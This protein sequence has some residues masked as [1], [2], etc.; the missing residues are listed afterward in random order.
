[1]VEHYRN[2][3]TAFDEK[4]LVRIGEAMPSIFR[5]EIEPLAL[6]THENLLEDYYTTA[7]GMP[8]TYAQI[9]RYVTM[10]SHKHPN[11]D[12][13][14]IGAGTGGTTVPVLR[15]LKECEDRHAYSYPRLKAYTYTDISSYFF[16]RTAEKFEDFAPF[17]KFKKLDIDEDPETQDFKPTSYDVIVAANVLHAT[18]D[19]HRTMTHVRKLLRPGAKLILLE[20]TNRLLAASVIFG[21]LPG[22]WNASEPWRTDGP[23]LTETQWENVLLCNGFSGLQASSPDVLGPL[24]EGTMLMIATAVETKLNLC[25][26]LNTPPENPHIVILH[27]DS[28]IK[29]N[30]LNIPLAVKSTIE[31]SGLQVQLLCLSRLTKQ[32][33]TDAVCISFV[34][35][36]E[37]ILAGPSPTDLSTLQSIADASAGLIW[38]TLGVSSSN[39]ES[40]ELAVF[41]GL[42]RTLRAEHEGLPCISVDLDAEKHLPAD[43]VARLLFR[44]VEKH[45]RP[46]SNPKGNDSEFVE[47]AGVLQ[48]KR[49]IEDDKSNKFL[50][51]RTDLTS[52]PPLLGELELKKR[53]LKLKLIKSSLSNSFVFEDDPINLQPLQSHEVEIQVR[54]T[55]IS[56][57]DVRILKDEIK[58]ALLGQECSGIITNTGDAVSDLA[59]GDHVVAWCSNNFDTHVHTPASFVYKMLDAVSFELAA[60]VPI[61]HVTAYYSLIHVVRMKAGETVLVHDAANPVGQVAVQIATKLDA[62]IFATVRSEEEKSHLSEVYHMDRHCIFSSQDL[63]FVIALRRAT[64]GRGVDVVLNTLTGEALQS[65]LQLC[66]AIWSLCRAWEGKLRE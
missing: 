27:A 51:A 50:T 40:P 2:H 1:M 38:V 56:S 45:F 22:W 43:E 39:V 30:R 52:L 7:V 61:K 21:T 11:L 60:T 17:M 53:P 63:N 18:S 35:L 23:L 57:R 65:L 46:G 12:S 55:S 33:I 16:Q 29:I 14:E 64:K 28:P 19:I 20:M 58:G 31:A 54:A 10:L 5:Q 9:S 36:N 25:H 66:R 3:Q 24:E 34:E 48:I 4:L 13:L 47:R 49:A 41:Q 44:I 8:N 15:S 6:M 62:K 42:A 37:P 26:G 59:I 32:D